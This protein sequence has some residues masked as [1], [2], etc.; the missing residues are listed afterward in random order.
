M[1]RT[2]AL[3]LAAGLPL[4]LLAAGCASSA[5]PFRTVLDDY[6]Q[7][8]DLDRLR[9]IAPM[10][11]AGFRHEDQAMPSTPEAYLGRFQNV[12]QAELSIEEARAS[13]ISHNLNLQ[14]SL[15][16]PTIA[17]QSV[18]EEEARWESTFNLGATLASNDS[19]T[20]SRLDSAQSDFARVEPSFDIPMRTGGSVSVGLPVSRNQTNNE[21]ST[22][23]PA[24]TSDLE[25]S[26]THQLLRNAG[27]RANTHSLRIAAYNSQISSANTRLQVIQQLSAVDRQYWALFG[28]RQALVV[29]EEEY[30]VAE[31]QLARA[32]RQFNAGSVA[33]IEVTRAESGLADR[34]DGIIRARTN[35][36]TAQR[37]LKR[38]INIPGLD[39]ES[40]TE[41]VPT[42]PP[43]P[44]RFRFDRDALAAEAVDQR[45]EMLELEL[46]LLA[47]ASSIQ[48]ARNQTLPLLSLQALYRLNGLGP[49][50]GESI[51]TTAE[52]E[53]EDWSLSLNASIPIGNEA[54]LARLRQAV[55][56]RVQR[57][58]TRAAR[59]QLIRQEVFDAIDEVEA[60]WQ[61][62]MAARQSVVLNVRSLEA[63]QRQFD[64]GAS[65]STDVLDAS[66]ALAVARLAEIQAIVDYQIALVDLAAATG[67]LIGSAR[68]RWEPTP[69]DP[70]M[71]EFVP[72]S[73]REP[74]AAQD[75]DNDEG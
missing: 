14:V 53:F 60:G 31:A 30:R 22:L 4:A 74:W 44:A 27:R 9:N 15:L 26:L 70:A 33:Q 61:R 8:V 51:E 12:E 32:Q 24:Y 36:T 71:G 13:A 23:N 54:A 59:A 68:V 25:I 46:R 20:G 19:P 57:L 21:F 17:G 75:A 39:V 49:D 34:I 65:T 48:F 62:I 63:E 6:G 40:G 35:I 64:V 42:S 69:Y 47:D 3:P 7:R 50:F 56:T 52:N 10:D 16:E 41:L 67:T 18:D 5:N 37:E 38:I 66:A 28:Q 58:N 73:L 29:R 11:P 45:M 72:D 43:D 55:L 1:T 2:V